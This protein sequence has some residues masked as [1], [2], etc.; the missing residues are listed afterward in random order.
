MSNKKAKKGKKKTDD[1]NVQIHKMYAIADVVTKLGSELFK[2]SALVGIAYFGYESI[3]VIAG[4]VTLADISFSWFMSK[5]M[6]AFLGVL[7]GAGG[8]VYGKRQARLRKDTIARLHTYQE[9]YELTHDPS[10]T[11]SYLTKRGDTRD[12]D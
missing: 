8:I 1:N 5:D 6:A 4:K 3:S 7:V 2:W 11:S 12:G 10:R 9:K